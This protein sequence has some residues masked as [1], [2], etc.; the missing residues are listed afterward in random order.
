MVKCPKCNAHIARKSSLCPQCGAVLSE[1]EKGVTSDTLDI[2]KHYGDDSGQS[3]GAVN[4]DSAQPDSDP[5]A[6]LDPSPTTVG[7]SDRVNN[8]GTLDAEIAVANKYRTDEP[9][10]KLSV[11]ES[12]AMPTLDP[13]GGTVVAD[14]FGTVDSASGAA[15]IHAA[16]SPHDT[17]HGSD[18]THVGD[19]YATVDSMS[20]E[21]TIHTAVTPAPAQANDPHSTVDSV[22]GPAAE[23]VPENSPDDSLKTQLLDEAPSSAGSARGKSGTEGR[24]RRLWEGAAGSSHDPMHSLKDEGQASGSVFNR[25]ATRTLSEATEK[26]AETADYQLIQK[27]GEGAMGIVFAARQKAIDRVVAL[28][29]VKQ[30]QQKSDDSR[31]K[32]FYE[33]QITGELDHPN[34]VP[35]HE[36][37]SSEQ[38]LL[39]YSMKLVV[40][41]PWQKAIAEKS[42]EENLDILMKVADAIG[43]AHSKGVIHRDLKPENIMLGAF[44][45][46]LVMDWGLA[47]SFRRK[48][49]FGLGGTPAFMAPEMARHDISQ[50]GPRSDIYLLG[51]MLFQLITGFPPHPG[52]TVTRCLQAAL[53]N[54]IIPVPK[55]DP[56]LEIAYKAMSRDVEDRYTTVAEMQEAIR[57]YRR[58]AESISLTNRANA[59]L[60]NAIQDQDY[61]AFSRSLFGFRDAADM[62]AEN[63]QAREGIKRCRLA[64]G[65]CAFKRADYDLCLQTLDRTVPEE[66][67]LY[68]AAEKEK[69]A[70]LNREK[71]VK[72]LK[73][74]VAV[75]VLLAMVGLSGL[76]AVAW[77]QRGQAIANA[78]TAE[79]NAIEAR[80]QEGIAKEQTSVAQM[81]TKLA[82][83]KTAEADH[84]RM[85]AVMAKEEETRQR[86]AADTARD[87]ADMQRGIAEMKRNEAEMATKAAL[88]AKE[89]ETRAKLEVQQKAAEVQLGN[90]QTNLSLALAQLAQFDTSK[91]M[92]SLTAARQSLDSEQFAQKKPNLDLWA[93]RRI[94]LLGNSDLP[95]ID[96]GNQVTAIDFATDSRRGVIGT[97]DGK[98][99]L[100]DFDGRELH[101]LSDRALKYDSEIEGVAISPN[102]KSV[103]FSIATPG[104][105]NTVFVWQTDATKPTE[106]QATKQRSLQ[107]FAISS[108]GK[109]IVGGVNEGMW[110]WKRAGA[111]DVQ[112]LSDPTPQRYKNVKGRLKSLQLIGAAGEKGVVVT[113]FNGALACY[114]IDFRTEK[115]RLIF[116]PLTK[117]PDLALSSVKFTSIAHAG[118]LNKL[119]LGAETGQIF[120]ADLDAN[121]AVT[122]IEELL[123]KIH[124][125]AVRSIRVHPTE[126][127]LLTIGIEP[128]VH[129]WDRSAGPTGWQYNTFLI[130]TAGNVEST[131]FAGSPNE[132]LGVD[133][134]GNMLAWNVQRQKQRRQL[135]PILP[136][137]S[138]YAFAAPVLAVAPAADGN[139]ALTVDT[140]GVLNQW[141]LADG[142]TLPLNTDSR[143]NY[144]G[145]TPGA[146]FVDMAVDTKANILVTSATLPVQNRKYV[147]DNNARAEFCLWNL[148]AGTMTRRWTLDT[149]TEPRISLLDSGKSLLIA[150]DSDTTI[151]SLSNDSQPLFER[152]DFGTFM[153]IPHPSTPNLVML[154]N[155][156]RAVRAFKLDDESSWENP[157]FRQWYLADNT[158]PPVQAAW[159]PAGDQFYMVLA[160]GKI[161]KMSWSGQQIGM[162]EVVDF[163]EPLGLA[164]VRP[165]TWRDLD[166]Q[167]K[168]EQGVDTFYIATRLPGASSNTNYAK[169]R[170]SKSGEKSTLDK[171]NVA[172]RQWLVARNPQA[173]PVVQAG[174]RGVQ[175]V[176]TVEESSFVATL[177]AGVYRIQYQPARSVSVFARKP[178]L[179]ASSNAAGNRIITLQEDHSLWRADV[180]QQKQVS[181]FPI[182]SE[183]IDVNG[184]RLSPDGKQLLLLGKAADKHQAR[185]IDPTSGNVLKVLDGIQHGDWSTS[186]DLAIFSADGKIAVSTAAG[187]SLQLALP[188]PIEP[189]TVC[190]QLKFFTEAWSSG[191]PAQPYLIVLTESKKEDVVEF[192]RLDKANPLT[193]PI[194]GVFAPGSVT[195][196]ATSPNESLFVIGDKSGTV[197]VWFATPTYAYSDPIPKDP[198]RDDPTSTGNQNLLQLFTLEGHRGAKIESLN[199][200]L[201]GHTLISTDN[202]NRV[203]GWL[204]V[205]SLAGKPAIQKADNRLARIE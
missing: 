164:G 153:A 59:Q 163:S 1:A 140:N 91:S 43:F 151:R 106:L 11:P 100:F 85:V 65:N 49:E 22:S 158:D 103:I 129:V 77:W 135:K 64:Y 116:P 185:L 3:P 134:R 34:I 80:T 92:Q 199:F 121:L 32:F 29:A 105:T 194:R 7:L 181:W 145:H 4:N 165:Q 156:S 170:F 157:G 74:T 201:D 120:V 110:V 138:D 41:T 8:D 45:E 97:R 107:G 82:E 189:G 50:I 119:L 117:L 24:L 178:I 175:K 38:G 161:S 155:R 113:D 184:I 81:Q 84:E 143:V 109:R 12:N 40:G 57:Q 62:W 159:S 171:G 79:N 131:L 56:L 167:I 182:A 39:F 162:P 127:T 180:D 28:K 166:L 61:E 54:E 205:D 108:D 53:N 188:R 55:S 48:Q 126:G 160:S 68:L 190:K 133:E 154:V 76:S 60:K 152:K 36:L 26:G 33:A 179:A 204:S 177:D 63:S 203:F 202:Q 147:T 172:G 14:P 23:D 183:K 19:L 78:I 150:D 132:V 75:V 25:V 98:V 72:S 5:N 186:G 146:R 196:L 124:Q 70:A 27:L 130:G 13:T 58:H 128:V 118:A 9:V 123:P 51:A 114:E 122:K 90:F 71:R 174:V 15:T 37:G 87:E 200:T 18:Q 21:A 125:S 96:F 17:H 141:S 52:Q 193:A 176:L 6:T 149:P 47:V 102:G 20:G 10:A 192:I 88:A 139:S 67:K 168:R 31:R 66:D 46:V 73:R 99:E 142:H 94:S 104:Q 187:E 95:K 111:N 115:S 16:S 148:S 197:S 86:T 83:E 198:K 89:A 136:D 2:A 42:R 69:A 30:G 101:T 44:G 169:L 93:M 137:G 173:T 112:W 144:F 35:I 195:A 191:Q